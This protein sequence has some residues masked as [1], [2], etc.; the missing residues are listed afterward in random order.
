MRPNTT[1]STPV[2]PAKLT[3]KVELKVVYDDRA[4][5]KQEATYTFHVV[6]DKALDEKREE[7]ADKGLVG[8][9]ENFIGT[10]IPNDNGIAN[11]R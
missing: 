9:V 11:E 10:I 2:D 1:V 3:E 7:N 8:E 4:N 5:A 6:K